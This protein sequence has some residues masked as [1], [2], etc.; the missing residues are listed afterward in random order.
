MK[1]ET[2]LIII[3]ILA[4]LSFINS[5]Y[6]AYD[7]IFPVNTISNIYQIW[8]IK[9]VPSKICDINN[10][11]SC[12]IVANSEYSKLFWIPFWIY[13]MFMFSLVIILW[14]VWLLKKREDIFKLILVPVWAW[15]LTNFYLFY[16]EIFVIWVFCPVCIWISIF[17]FSI[18]FI[19]LHSVLKCTTKQ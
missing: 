8:D 16:L 15:V 3:I 6:L 12:T 14:F 19:S 2:K 7:W 5:F 11:F 9:E 13:A 18:F 4:I 10:L 1:R 17:L